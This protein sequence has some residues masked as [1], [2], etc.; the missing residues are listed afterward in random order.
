MERQRAPERKNTMSQNGDEVDPVSFGKRELPL[1]Y[2]GFSV[3]HITILISIIGLMGGGVWALRSAAQDLRTEIHATATEN[4]QAVKDVINRMDQRMD[5]IVAGIAD[6]GKVEAVHTVR[7]EALE[8]QEHAL[9]LRQQE[10]EHRFD[11]ALNEIRIQLSSILAEQRQ[12]TARG[13]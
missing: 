12:Q 9:D 2:A 10:D 7:I 13:K 4:R 8:Q 6:T 3:P 1:T 5:S 11:S